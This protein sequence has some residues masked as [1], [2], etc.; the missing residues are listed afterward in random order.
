MILTTYY[1]S[2][3][4]R[5]FLIFINCSMLSQCEQNPWKMDCECPYADLFMPSELNLIYL[6]NM[7][8]TWLTYNMIIYF[9]FFFLVY[10][11]GAQESILSILNYERLSAPF[12]YPGIGESFIQTRFL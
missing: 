9:I 11:R 1:N 2:S 5:E 10:M 12:L 3:S 8:F 7:D 6:E 4:S